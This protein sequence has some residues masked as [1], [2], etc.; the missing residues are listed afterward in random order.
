M[1]KGT[2]FSFKT[3]IKKYQNL[4]L[5]VIIMFF[6]FIPFYYYRRECSKCKEENNCCQETVLK[7][8]CDVDCTTETNI[9][10]NDLD[11]KGEWSNWSECSSSCGSGIS[12][13]TYNIIRESSPG[14]LECDNKDG[15]IEEKTCKIKECPIDCVGYWTD[16]SNCT[17]NCEPGGTQSKYFIVTK[18]ASNGGDICMDGEGN[19]LL[20]GMINTRNCNTDI[21]CPVDCIGEWDGWSECSE[22]C[23]GGTK[24]NKYKVIRPAE[25]GG[26]ECLY[27]DNTVITSDCNTLE[28]I[29]CVGEWSGWSD[30]DAEC[31]GGTRTNTYNI[32]VQASNHGE[33]CRD[34]NGD[35]LNDGYSISEECN[36][37]SCPQHC[38]GSWSEYSMCLDQETRNPVV[39]GDSFKERT[40]TTTVPP[41]Y[42]GDTCLDEQNI[43]R[44]HGEKDIFQCNI[45]HTREE[46]SIVYQS[47]QCSEC[48]VNKYVDEN[49]KCQ[50][51]PDGLKRDEIDDP[52]NGETSCY[53]V[54]CN[55][56]E[57]RDGYN[58][59]ECEFGKDNSNRLNNNNTHSQTTCEDIICGVN[60]YV[61]DF[62]CLSCSDYSN[63]PAGD[64]VLS[65]DTECEPEYCGEDQYVATYLDYS[66]S[67]FDG[68]YDCPIGFFYNPR[69]NIDFDIEKLNKNKYPDHNHFNLCRNNEGLNRE[70][71]NEQMNYIEPSIGTTS[72]RYNTYKCKNDPDLFYV[73][74]YC[75]CDNDR[76]HKDCKLQGYRQTSSGNKWI[77]TYGQ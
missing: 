31:G 35:I 67:W 7:A 30:C 18:S 16:W 8:F 49:R 38:V 40:Y 70:E 14:G 72:H 63:R 64:R 76:N 5:F 56:N 4:F 48:G 62:E 20:N 50:D 55:V 73:D 21:P 68:C 9:G 45:D 13:R 3:N 36:T 77:V 25:N 59:I 52:N 53:E 60:E 22:L 19:E 17:S 66:S 32:S 26:E 29:D 12:K 46:T 69:D 74:S 58:C 75:N 15:I 1:I 39:C 54:E 10:D 28:C 44:Y 71:F 61:K 24:T 27:E 42:G 47:T 34:D 65:G 33:E 2:N 37:Q 43:E 41:L 57:K 6:I 51:C 23:G 11:C